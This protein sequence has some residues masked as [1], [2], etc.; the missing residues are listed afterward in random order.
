MMCMFIALLNTSCIWN[1]SEHII[2]YLPTQDCDINFWAMVPNMCERIIN[3]YSTSVRFWGINL[4]VEIHIVYRT[5]LAFHFTT[6]IMLHALLL[7]TQTQW[8]KDIYSIRAVISGYHFNGRFQRYMKIYNP[9]RAVFGV[10]FCWQRLG[11]E[12]SLHWQTHYS[13]YWQKLNLNKN[14]CCTKVRLPTLILL[15]RYSNYQLG[16]SV[17]SL[18]Y[19]HI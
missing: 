7:F 4:V 13:F 2:L 3:I 15:D 18:F 17:C 10:S 12:V 5:V 9:R 11:Y 14:I 1:I 16:I 8:N 6:N 19:N